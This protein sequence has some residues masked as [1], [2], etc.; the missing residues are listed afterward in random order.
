MLNWLQSLFRVGKQSKMKGKK[1][2]VTLPKKYRVGYINLIVKE[3]SDR[4]VLRN[5][6][7][8]ILAT[9]KHETNNTFK[10]V[11]E[12]YWLSEGWRKRNLRY[13]PWHGRGFVQ[14]TWEYNYKKASDKLGVDFI[15]DPDKALDPELSA[16]ILVVG[17]LEGWFTGKE[18]SDYITLKKSDF[19]NARR[20][21]N[22]MD[23]ADLIAKY[24]REYDKVLKEAGYD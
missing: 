16:K 22:G 12:A 10:P 21:V 11:V 13:Y 2:V 18:L 6:L 14:L 5:Q 1:Q 9:T 20:I 19:R 3:A 24:A 17:M 7:A 23:D 4:G 8:Y 15:A